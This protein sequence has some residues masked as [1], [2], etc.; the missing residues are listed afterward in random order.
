MR[1]ASVTAAAICDD[2]HL[3]DALLRQRRNGHRVRGGLGVARGLGGL[4]RELGALSLR[5]LTLHCLFGLSLLA[6]ELVPE[7]RGDQTMLLAAPLVDFL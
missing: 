1:Q 3:Q 6:L 5:F 2:L 4:V 7:L